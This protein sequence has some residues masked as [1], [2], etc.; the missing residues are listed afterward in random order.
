[1]TESR[2]YSFDMTALAEHLRRQ[3]DL[4]RNAAY[5]NIDILK[6]QVWNGNLREYQ[7]ILYR[8]FT[9]LCFINYLVVD[10]MPYTHTHTQFLCTSLFLSFYK[11][12]QCFDAV[13][14][15][16]GRGFG[17]QKL[18]GGML[19]WLFVWGEMQICI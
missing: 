9:R 10:E 3:I 1:M 12:L 17:L 7:F 2:E 15:A 5:F 18:S 14:W 8:C 4:N 13:G 16:A 6:Y 19:A 11:C